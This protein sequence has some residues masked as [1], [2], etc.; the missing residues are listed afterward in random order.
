MSDRI[1]YRTNTASAAQI[2]AHLTQCNDS[3]IPKL[4]ARVDICAYAD[5]LASKAVRFEAWSEDVLIGLVAAYC[6]DL[7]QRTAFITSVSVLPEWTGKGIASALLAQ[8]I[9]HVRELRMRRLQLEVARDNQPAIK[10][11]ERHG[12]VIGNSDAQ[13]VTA[14]LQP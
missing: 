3:F 10:L 12:F 8:C 11:Y 4:S 5:K 9:A 7:E 1:E 2:A 6:N 14:T 13:F